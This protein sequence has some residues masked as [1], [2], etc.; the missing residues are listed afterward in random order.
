V[1]APGVFDL[2][3][4][5]VGSDDEDVIFRITIDGPINNHW[6]SPNGL[7]AQTL[8]LYIASTDHQTNVSYPGRI[9]P[10][11]EFAGTTSPGWRLDAEFSEAGGR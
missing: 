1:F 10:D 9:P 11:P 2:T 4:L 7:S 8:D 5:I 6:G 3:Q